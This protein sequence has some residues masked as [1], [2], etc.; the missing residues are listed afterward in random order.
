MS[1]QHSRL[2]LMRP[3]VRSDVM[4]AS[5][6]SPEEADI[7]LGA[8]GLPPALFGD[9][10]VDEL[11]GGEQRRAALAGLVASRPKLLVLDEPFAGLDTAGRLELTA[12]LA[13][14]RAET[15]LALVVVSHDT[16]GT[17]PFVDRVVRLDRGRLI[18]APVVP[19]P[20][21]VVGRMPRPAPEMHLLR[22]VPGDTPLHRMWAGTKM[23]ALVALTLFLSSEPKWGA[24]GVVALL[25]AIG[26]VVGRIPL[27]A[28]PRLPKWFWLAVVVAGFLSAEA[29]GK[30]TVHVGK[31]SIG[32]GAAEDWL[33]LAVLTVV[34]LVA[35]AMVAW[36]TPLGGVA[37]AFARLLGPLKRVRLPVDEWATTIGLTFRCLPLLLAEIHT[38]ASVRRLRAAHRQAN[39]PKSAQTLGVVD[40][41]TAS[42]VVG[43]RRA[44]ELADA[45]DARGG[46]KGIGDDRARPGR[47]DL[48]MGAVVALAIVAG[49]VAGRL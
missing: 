18:D 2:Q 4:Y 33:R 27:G 5:G 20:P 40:L 6:C 36:T 21:K 44:G 38:L 31:T 14:L 34:I 11:S 28:L 37:P 32:L 24:I 43:L 13:G 47:R 46:L 30:P 48:I 35:A 23:L 12:V 3:W 25:V 19:P 16:E 26:F 17:E 29:G 41:L 22:V 8:V 42:M 1:F 7:A 39:A 15:G 10:R 45:I 49:A 9:R